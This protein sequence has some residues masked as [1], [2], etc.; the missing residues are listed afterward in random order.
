MKSNRLALCLVF[1]AIT[2]AACGGAATVSPTSTPTPPVVAVELNPT[3]QR[4]GATAVA[5]FFD[6]CLSQPTSDYG[7]SDSLCHQN[8]YIGDCWFY[9]T[10]CIGKSFKWSLVGDPSSELRYTLDSSGQLQAVGHYLM[11][12]SF[13][14]QDSS[15]HDVSAGP[16][17][18][19][20]VRNGNAFTVS[21]LTSGQD[22]QHQFLVKAPGLKDP[23]A[24]KAVLLA[25]VKSFFE[26]CAGALTSEGAPDCPAVVYGHCLPAPVPTVWTIKGDPAA[27]ARVTWNGE[28]GVYSVGGDYRFHAAVAAGCTGRSSFSEDVGGMYWATVI[29][30]QSQPQVVT[31]GGMSDPMS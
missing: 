21:G 18:A 2:Q 19:R 5:K 1:L 6:A 26:A 16:F 3:D 31:I 20:L 28:R 12:A 17:I 23:G 8:V 10:L 11:E 30:T 4:A 7:I 24:D 25:A 9:T 29:W 15:R 22:A 13:S 27:G 14:T